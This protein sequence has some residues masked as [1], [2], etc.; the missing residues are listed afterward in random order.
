MV[1]SQDLVL[2]RAE[3]SDDAV[4]FENKE[5]R[6]LGSNGGSIEDL[7]KDDNFNLQD[8]EWI[9]P[10][11]CTF[12]S[13]LD[14]SMNSIDE[15]LSETSDRVE[16]LQYSV[17]W[18]GG[19]KFA[20]FTNTDG[21]C[22]ESAESAS[23][24]KYESVKDM[25][26]TNSSATS[27]SFDPNG[28]LQG[29]PYEVPRA[30]N[31]QFESL[32]REKPEETEM[33]GTVNDL[34]SSKVVNEHVHSCDEP[35]SFLDPARRNTRG[36]KSLHHILQFYKLHV[37]FMFYYLI[38]LYYLTFIYVL[39]YEVSKVTFIC[40]IRLV[41]KEVF[42]YGFVCIILNRLRIKEM[43]AFLVNLSKSMD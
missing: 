12:T 9:S 3:L 16:K 15:N 33:L 34:G 21:A 28:S 40:R 35:S 41:F 20:S 27:V 6:F 31:S 2:S 43:N 14:S 42:I 17:E 32:E 11:E 25:A 23:A 13:S 36:K 4:L 19:D 5:K 7:T 8:E 1:R 39:K 24:I 29:L 10:P 38:L 22:A 26:L 30:R 18:G 37:I